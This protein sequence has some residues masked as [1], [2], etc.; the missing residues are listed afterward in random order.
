MSET[1]YTESSGNLFAD[2]GLPNPEERQLKARL[3]SLINRIIEQRGLKQREAAQQLALT[4][5]KISDLKHGRLRSFSVEKLLYML[6]KLDSEVTIVIQS[7][8]D[9]SQP[10]A[11]IVI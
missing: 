2:M 3:A 4:Q 5:P 10:P 6:D 8:H 7:R 1:E 11:H 9:P